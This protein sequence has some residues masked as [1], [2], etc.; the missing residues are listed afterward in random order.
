MSSGPVVG[1]IVEIPAGRGVVRFV[2]S[3]KFS[4][5][6]WIGVELYEQK[7]KNDGTVNG[8]AYFPCKP[9]HGMFVRPSQVKATIGM[10]EPPPTPV[11]RSCLP[12]G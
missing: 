7:G 12:R 5:G 11:S 8:E 2:G 10:E 9:G 1:S 4:P 6:N 3:T